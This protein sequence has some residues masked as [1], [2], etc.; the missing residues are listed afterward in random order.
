[1]CGGEIDEMIHNAGEFVHYHISEPMLEPI[2]DGVVDQKSGI[3][4]LRTIDY[5][6]WVSIEMKQPTSVE[7]LK[8]WIRCI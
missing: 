4:T 3:E 5:K 7:L 8:E 1:M 2:S 6:E